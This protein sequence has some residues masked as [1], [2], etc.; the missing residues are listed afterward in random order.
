MSKEELVAGSSVWM[1]ESLSATLS[2]DFFPCDE[3]ETPFSAVGCVKP[4]SW[5]DSKKASLFRGLM[6]CKLKLGATTAPPCWC[7]FLMQLDR[8]ETQLFLKF[9]FMKAYTIGL[10]KLLKKPIA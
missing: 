8:V 1:V 10:L 6:N 2:S 4:L 3:L 7:G 9:S 5:L